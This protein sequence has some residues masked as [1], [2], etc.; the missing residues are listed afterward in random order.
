MPPWV[1]RQS[2]DL[3]HPSPD[4]LALEILSIFILA[5]LAVAFLFDVSTAMLFARFGAI[6]TGV[7]LAG[8]LLGA[9]LSFFAGR[10]GIRV[11]PIAATLYF[12]MVLIAGLGAAYLATMRVRR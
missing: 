12:G 9:M 1:V 3:P 7:V 8:M 5:W 10:F 11:P 4:V 2:Q 6:A